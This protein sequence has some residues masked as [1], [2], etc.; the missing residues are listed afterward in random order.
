MRSQIVEHQPHVVIDQERRGAGIR[1]LPQLPAELAALVGVEAGRRLVEAE[2]T[3]PHRDRAGHAD[4]LPLSLRQ[5]ARHR[6]GERAYLEQRQGLVGRR[7]VARR[8]T[9]ELG[10]ECQPRGALGGD[11][12][13]LAHRE[14]VE[15]LG[16]LPR[17]G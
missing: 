14:I 17:A 3:R 12:E 5:L 8:P 11:H 6:V 15:Q 13:V 9:D 10:C 1:D 4:E 7:V 16:A 2:E